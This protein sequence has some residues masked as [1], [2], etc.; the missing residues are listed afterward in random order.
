MPNCYNH[1]EE[2]LVT[3][4]GGLRVITLNRPAAEFLAQQKR[5]QRQ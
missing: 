4:E 3:A 2:M 1:P 5:N